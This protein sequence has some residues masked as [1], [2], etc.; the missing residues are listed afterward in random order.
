VYG[1]QRRQLLLNQGPESSDNSSD[2]E[3]G[4]K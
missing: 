2:I 4:D 3:S 1:E